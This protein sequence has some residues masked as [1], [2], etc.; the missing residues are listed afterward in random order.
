MA[1]N[2]NSGR[3]PKPPS[4]EDHLSELLLG[5]SSVLVAMHAD[6]TR[7]A[8]RQHERRRTLASLLTNAHTTWRMVRGQQA[9]V[10]PFPKR[11]SIPP[12]EP[13]EQRVAA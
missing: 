1:G 13:N 6:E 2:K 4:P 9:D 7:H 10:I 3:R 8:R 12:T 11:P 5:A